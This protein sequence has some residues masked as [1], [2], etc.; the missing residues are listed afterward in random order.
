MQ[1]IARVYI[2]VPDQSTQLPQEII[3]VLSVLFVG[4]G[5]RSIEECPRIS[6]GR[7]SFSIVLLHICKSMYQSMFGT[8]FI[9]IFRMETQTQGIE[10]HLFVMH[11]FF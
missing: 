1:R 7:Q 11:E 8:Y 5:P 6:G 2:L 3:S 4:L 10:R 9:A